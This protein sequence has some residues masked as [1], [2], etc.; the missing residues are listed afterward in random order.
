M[1][2]KTA[3]LTGELLDAAVAKAEGW[4]K[5]QWS[6]HEWDWRAEP[7]ADDDIGLLMSDSEGHSPSTDWA[8]GGPIIEREQI[9][10]SPSVDQGQWEA[11]VLSGHGYQGPESDHWM[12]GDTPLI[13][14]MRAYVA[15]KLGEEVELNMETSSC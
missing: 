6:A 4:H 11:G 10:V 9:V 7:T 15:H 1:K 8:Q 5:H 3:E 12:Y 13:A 2:Y 14:A